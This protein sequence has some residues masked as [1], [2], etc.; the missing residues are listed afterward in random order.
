MELMGNTNNTVTMQLIN[1]Q[2]GRVAADMKNSNGT[3]TTTHHVF[4]CWR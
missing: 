1:W 3:R 2:H 4:F